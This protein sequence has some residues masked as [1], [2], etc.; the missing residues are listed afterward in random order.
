ME[1]FLIFRKMLSPVIIQTLF[2]ISVILCI[3]F[4]IY[5]MWGGGFRILF[6]LL[7]LLLGPFVIRIWCETVLLLFRINRNLT[8]IRRNT[9]SSRPQSS[10]GDG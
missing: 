2:L 5:L 4:G 9:S 7:L 6:G 3:I 1:D 10:D 8:E